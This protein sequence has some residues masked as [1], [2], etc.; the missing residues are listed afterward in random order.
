MVYI[1]CWSLVLAIARVAW[2]SGEEPRPT[3]SPPLASAGAPTDVAPAR[4]EATVYE[5]QVPENLIAGLDAQEL[6]AKAA[7]AQDLAK[8]LAEFGKTRALY[9]IDQTVN[10]YDEKVNLGTQEPTVTSTRMTETGSAINTVMYQRVGLIVGIAGNPP[11]KDSKRKGL[12]VCITFELSALADSGVELSPK[13]KAAVT[14]SMHLSHGETPRFGR[15]RV[16]LNVSGPGGGE[17]AQPVAYVI[18]Y[19]FSEIKP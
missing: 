8:A 15:P 17:K 12:D 14:R 5:V 2:C 16:M 4:F 7:T 18:R 13:V 3:R 6:E 9:K 1:G 11:P 10:L 19:M